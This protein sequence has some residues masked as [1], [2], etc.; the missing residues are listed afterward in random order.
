VKSDNSPRLEEVVQKGDENTCKGT[1]DDV[2]IGGEDANM[3]KR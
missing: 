2:E 1:E 3:R